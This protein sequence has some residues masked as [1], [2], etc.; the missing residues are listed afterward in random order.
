ML[1]WHLERGL[2]RMPVLDY[3]ELLEAENAALRR[4]LGGAAGRGAAAAQEN[5]K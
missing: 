3:L 4:Q 1:R 5:T 2:E